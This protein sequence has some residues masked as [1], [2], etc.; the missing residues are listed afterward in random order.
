MLPRALTIVLLVA[1]AV[2]LFAET[3][4]ITAH[5]GAR[6]FYEKVGSGPRTVIIPGGLFLH[7][8]MDA[9]AGGRTLIY[10]D[11]RNRG[12]SS[13]VEDV[14]AIT[15]EN[16]VRDLETVRA[17]FKVAK[18]SLIGYSYLGMMVVLYAMEHPERVERIVQIGPVPLDFRT[19]FPTHLR[20]DDRRQVLDGEK[21]K[22]VEQWRQQGWDK[23]RPKEFCEKQWAMFRRLLVGTAE[24]QEK[25]SSKCEFEN[26]WPVNFD[27]HLKAHF[28]GSVQNLKVP[29]EQVRAKVKHPV[30]TLHGTLDRNA[31]YGAGRDWQLILPNARL[32]TVKGAAHQLWVDEPAALQWIDQFLSGNWPQKAEKIDQL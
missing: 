14:S 12:R 10:Y 8:D 22:E 2:P 23:T 19:E 30:L 18:A 1:G 32:I 4:Y 25:L 9:L 13:R 17:H 3:G 27:R 24:N 21:Y 6:L 16:D 7:P 28:E 15:I 31:P 20:N 5:D 29:R 11:M 26:E